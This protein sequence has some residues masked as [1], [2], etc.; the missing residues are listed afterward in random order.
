MIKRTTKDFVDGN[1]Y[2]LVAYHVEGKRHEIV[3]ISDSY[4]ASK[5]STVDSKPK[6]ALGENDTKVKNEESKKKDKEF[7]K[8]FDN[9][10]DEYI[11]Y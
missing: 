6:D 8:E 9:L 11:L 7:D 3:P 1:L 5:V 4:L 2:H 10:F